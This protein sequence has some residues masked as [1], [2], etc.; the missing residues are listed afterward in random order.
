[1]AKRPSPGNPFASQLEAARDTVAAIDNSKAYGD[2]V[3]AVRRETPWRF[4]GVKELD[5]YL[6]NVRHHLL[7]FAPMV[8]SHIDGGIRI[9]FDFG[10]GS[11]SGSIALALIFP[12]IHCHGV[13]IS[14]AEVAIGRERA[15][16]YGVA[17]RCQF[18]CIGAGQA[19][20]VPSNTFDLCTCCSVLEYIVNPNV[21]KFCVQEMTRVLIPGGRLVMSVPNRLYPIELH[22]LKLGWNY[23]PKLLKARIVGASAWEVMKLARPHVLKLCSN[24]VRQLWAPWSN[25]CLRKES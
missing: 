8:L 3:E 2:F 11:G 10:C 21:R 20:P 19:L 22:S 9:V 25:F 12:E 13:D 24:P 7:H 1:M 14:P 5:R 18:E 17:D 23:F 15:R 4:N 6:H 16:L